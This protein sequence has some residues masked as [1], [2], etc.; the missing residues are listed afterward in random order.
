MTIEQLLKTKIDWQKTQ[1]SEYL[2]SAFIEGKELYLRL[3]DFPEEPLC[4]VIID[5]HERNLDDLG[6][7]WTLP[8]HRGEQKPRRVQEIIL[9]S[10]KSRFK[11]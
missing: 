11:W 8:K 7:G 2:F 9:I 5:G 6:E 4:T 3:N 1:K 10:L